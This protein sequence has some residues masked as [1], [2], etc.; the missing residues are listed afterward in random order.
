MGS[1]SKEH[2]EAIR[3]YLSRQGMTFKPLQ[4]EMLDHVSCDIEKLIASGQ[5][6]DDAWQAIT[7]ELPL[8]QIQAIQIETMETINKKES[9]SKWL[10]YLSFFLLFAGSVFKLMKFP[11]TAQM[12]IGSF[13]AIA[14]AL[15]SGSAFGM[16]ANKGK[17]GSWL[18]VAVLTG[19][20]LFLASFTFQ[21]LHL[22][23]ATELRTMAV[24]LLCVS[25]VISFFY[26][27]GSDN[28]VLPWLHEKY[29]PAIERFLFILFTAVFV[30][31]MPSLILGYEDFMSRILLVIAIASAG[32]HFHALSWHAFKWNKRPT[33][34]YSLA[35]SVSIVCF[36]LP[37]LMGFLSLPVRA[38]LMVAFWPIAGAIV[39]VRSQEGN[40]RVAAFLTTGFI[41]LIYLLSALA[42]SEVLPAALNAFSFNGIVLMIL[43]AVLVVF[44]KNPFFRMYLLIAVSHYLFM[45]PW[46]LGLW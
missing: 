3:D 46:E 32:L 2:L 43:L 21:I 33:L 5:S 27:R 31:R 34:A 41:T 18:L 37:A 24:M 10:A 16:M 45:Y 11:G 13:V 14:L 9:L 40:T 1:L 8:K 29:T 12:L 26:L 35:L 7:K 19:V 39:A 23:G 30:I 20:L 44:R 42:S 38:G 25:Y 15:V 22:P 6:F 4:D 36:L 28:Y 17:R